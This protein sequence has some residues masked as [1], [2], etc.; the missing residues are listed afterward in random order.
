VVSEDVAA[1]IWPGEDPIGKRIKLD[2]LDS[3]AAWRTVVG[4]AR[5]TPYR[6]LAAPRPTLYIPAE[7]FIV[8]A[9][10]LILR[11]TSPLTLVAGQARERVRAVDP[12]VQVTRVAPFRELLC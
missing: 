4:V 3:T 12:D 11:T 5:P 8:A 1:R 6:D 9:E 10:I 2:R 7:Q